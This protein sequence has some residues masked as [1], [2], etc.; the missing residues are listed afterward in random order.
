MREI[1]FKC[2]YRGHMYDRVNLR[3]EPDYTAVEIIK[4]KG[5]N[6]H[7]D[8]TKATLLQFTNLTDRN[9]KHIYE[10]DVMQN[11]DGVGRS[12]VQWYHCGFN[13]KWI[14]IG[15]TS[16]LSL[17]TNDWEIIGNIYQNPELLKHDKD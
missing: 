3:I 11:E 4:G 14:P 9:G 8:T 10:G 13:R 2:W 15:V 16:P 17:N 7:T 12:V 1:K 5:N 6:V